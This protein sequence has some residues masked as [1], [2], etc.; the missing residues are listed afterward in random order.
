MIEALH[1]VDANPQENPGRY[2]IR[3]FISPK[4]TFN[5]HYCSPKNGIVT[6]FTVQFSTNAMQRWKKELKEFICLTQSEFP[7]LTIKT[8]ASA[9][10][11]IL[12]RPPN[13]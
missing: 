12:R 5:V 4:E 6:G 3:E 1:T 13:Q 7:E 2:M 9:L 8:I 10:F 11:K